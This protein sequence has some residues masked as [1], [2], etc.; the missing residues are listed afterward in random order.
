MINI[1]AF[2][3]LG[4]IIYFESKTFLELKKL[5]RIGVFKESTIFQLFKKLDTVDLSYKSE[6]INIKKMMTINKLL[7]LTLLTLLLYKVIS[8]W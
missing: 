3:L 1:F 5:E 6:V 8:K 4:L 2:L 7:K